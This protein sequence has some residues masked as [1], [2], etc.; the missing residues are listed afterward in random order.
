MDTNPKGTKPLLLHI[1]DR[2]PVN[3]NSDPGT[4]LTTQEVHYYKLPSDL[5]NNSY[6]DAAK[7]GLVDST[8][9]T[10]TNKHP[11]APTTPSPSPT[12]EG[13]TTN[14]N[15]LPESGDNAILLHV[16][17]PQSVFFN[18]I[19]VSDFKHLVCIK[20]WKHV[21]RIVF[22]IVDGTG[23]RA[24]VQVRSTSIKQSHLQQLNV[25]SDY[26]R[27]NR[28][29]YNILCWIC[30]Y[31]DLFYNVVTRY[32]ATQDGAL[33]WDALYDLCEAHQFWQQLVDQGKARGRHTWAR[34]RAYIKAT[35]PAD[36]HPLYGG[37]WDAAELKREV[38]RLRKA[39]TGSCA[40]HA[41]HTRGPPF[42]P[43]LDEY[44]TPTQLKPTEFES[45]F[46]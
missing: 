8:E 28:E 31:T 41:F 40:K 33:A 38:A 25:D 19:H 44:S 46:I 7:E 15:V 35:L 2:D 22:A 17:A 11:G 23:S 29:F 26:E 39:K 4:T 37:L 27:R 13:T 12:N 43:T 32:S 21:K 24:L 1:V 16:E 10:S 36:N 9:Q 5:F 45:N 6:A 34:A 18:N 14:T 3:P 42:M 30:A 20:D